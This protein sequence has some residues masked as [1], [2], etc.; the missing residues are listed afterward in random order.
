[1]LQR[2]SHIL[3]FL[4]LILWLFD[5]SVIHSEVARELISFQIPLKSI[6]DVSAFPWSH[7]TIRL[8]VSI[9]YW[10]IINSLRL[11]LLEQLPYYL[12][13]VDLVKLMNSFDL[14]TS[15]PTYFYL[16]FLV[17]SLFSKIS[18]PCIYAHT[19]TICL[20]MY[21]DV[22]TKF[23]WVLSPRTSSLKYIFLN[24]RDLSFLG[25]Q[26]DAPEKF[27]F[28]NTSSFK[29]IFPSLNQLLLSVSKTCCF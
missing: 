3:L 6:L 1:M 9:R 29:W 16:Y 5:L 14:L 2:L 10:L 21:I 28:F 23:M 17:I 18:S 13:L 26:Q 4:C 25:I 7:F 24:L 12:K 19:C 15:L 27:W 8:N 11:L 20:C 22:N